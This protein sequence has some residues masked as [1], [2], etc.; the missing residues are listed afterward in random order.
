MTWSV[1]LPCSYLRCYL[2][3]L[4]KLLDCLLLLLTSDEGIENLCHDLGKGDPAFRFDGRYE[5]GT[6]GVV[7]ELQRHLRGGF[8]YLLSWAFDTLQPFWSVGFGICGAGIGNG[9]AVA[10]LVCLDR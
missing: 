10:W 5:V 4:N 1:K 2:A 6:I 7:A 3:L 9:E 8:G